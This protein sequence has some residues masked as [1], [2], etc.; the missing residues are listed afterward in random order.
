MRE[1]EIAKA[2]PLPRPSL[3]TIRAQP[4]PRPDTRG[5]PV[6]WVRPAGRVEGRRRSDRCVRVWLPPQEHARS[7]R[8]SSRMRVVG[9]GHEGSVAP[10]AR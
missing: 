4:V 7:A 8:L 10:R 2:K 3:D 1:E 5:R 6:S 9:L